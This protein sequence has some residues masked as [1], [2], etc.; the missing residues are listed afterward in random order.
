MTEV[1]P[2]DFAVVTEDDDDVGLNQG[3][4]SNPIDPYL[5]NRQSKVGQ[6]IILFTI[7]SK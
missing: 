2:D 7:Q 3:C 1:S 5:D 6:S 4:Q